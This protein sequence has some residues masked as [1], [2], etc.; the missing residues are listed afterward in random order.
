MHKYTQRMSFDWL[1]F[2]FKKEPQYL[3]WILKDCT[4]LISFTG[5]FGTRYVEMNNLDDVV[6][7]ILKYK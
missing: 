3:E 6:Q 5:E 1:C 7:C 2:Y 4:V